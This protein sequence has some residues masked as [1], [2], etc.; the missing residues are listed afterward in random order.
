MHRSR[1]RLRL[2]LPN[3]CRDADW[4]QRTASRLEQLPDV[5][6]VD[7]T[8]VSGS[9]LIHHRAGPELMERLSSTGLFSIVDSPLSTPP[10][11]DRIAEGVYRSD[12]S[13][14]RRTGGRIN[15]RTL[16]ILVLIA[17][18]IV[19]SVRRRIMVPAITLL[20]FAAQLVFMS[21][22]NNR[23]PPS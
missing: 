21:K 14:E 1:G 22:N 12:R 9:L 6:R 18:A 3:K 2:K 4:L 16:L 5:E 19:Q 15:L 11:L 17:L 8:A 23:H 13:L 7:V 20:M 10:V